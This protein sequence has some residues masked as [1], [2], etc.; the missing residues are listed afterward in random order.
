MITY[1]PLKRPASVS[2]ALL[3]TLSLKVLC[4]L[5]NLLT[6][7]KQLLTHLQSKKERT[8]C[9]KENTVIEKGGGAAKMRLDRKDHED[10]LVYSER[11]AEPHKASFW[12]QLAAVEW[13]K[14]R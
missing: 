1:F 13:K 14:H 11:P 8:A 4:F 9:G 3:E 2:L 6:P 7:P 5:P 12:Y 10:Q